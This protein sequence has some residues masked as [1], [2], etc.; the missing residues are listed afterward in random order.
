MDSV[1]GKEG[2]GREGRREGGDKFTVLIS[3]LFQSFTAIKHVRQGARG[4]TYLSERGDNHVFG[5]PAGQKIKNK[6]R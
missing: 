4:K 3:H 6:K 1:G 5:V 2:G